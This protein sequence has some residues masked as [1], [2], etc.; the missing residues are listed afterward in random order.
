M[1]NCNHSNFLNHE[2]NNLSGKGNK[3]MLKL[4]KVGPFKGTAK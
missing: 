4:A 3:R 1:N 2:Q